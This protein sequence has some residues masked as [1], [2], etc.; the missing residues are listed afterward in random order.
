[1]ALVREFSCACYLSVGE[2]LSTTV[3]R[4][5]SLSRSSLSLAVGEKPN[6]SSALS[7]R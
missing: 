2:G 4:G 6:C 5:V 7:E 3:M 1:M